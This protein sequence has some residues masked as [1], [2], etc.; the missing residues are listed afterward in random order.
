MNPF[1]QLLRARGSKAP[2]GTWVLSA[3]PMVAEAVGLAGFDWG[4]LDMEHTPVDLMDLVH[5]LQAVGNTKMV[6]LVR[7]PWND[8]VTVKRVLDAGAQT[9]MFPFIQNA[10]EAQQA[11]AATRYPPEGVRG[12]VDM[13]RASRF[14]T[15]VDHL[16]TANK[17]IG[18][19]VQLE[20]PQ[21]IARLEEIASVPGVDALFVGP[22]DLSGAMGHVG[23]LTHPAVMTLMTDAARRARALGKPIGT[24]GG[25]PEA[26]TRYR[27]AGYDYV[28]IASD[29]GLLMRGAQAAVQ[30]LSHAP[31]KTQ[32]HSL[33]E[34]TRTDAAY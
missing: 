30:A 1:N 27:A 19:V 11:V 4:V 15:V 2:I 9:L 33:T 28:A 12:M 24:V 32:V 26:V 18:V 20:T 7:V 16:R 8:T 17:S 14:G 31:E 6:P 22:A 25:T 23:N 29:L 13:S 5:L 10:S 34:G 21:A 3:S